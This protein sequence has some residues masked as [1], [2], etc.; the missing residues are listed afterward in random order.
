M[1]VER[2]PL[3][4]VSESVAQKCDYLQ[5]IFLQNMMKLR[6]NSDTI[7]FINFNEKTNDIN[8]FRPYGMKKTQ[9]NMK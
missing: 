4:H 1:A 3:L 8:L 6:K 5:S 9:V 2:P 7:C